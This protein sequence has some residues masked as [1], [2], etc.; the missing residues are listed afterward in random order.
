MPSIGW[1]A[2]EGILALGLLVGVTACGGGGGS[3]TGDAGA[4]GGP[5]KVLSI[6]VGD[7]EV[8]EINRA[9]EI[10]FNKAVDFDTVNLNTIAIDAMGLQ[11]QAI[12]PASGEFFMKT[13]KVVVFQPTCPLAPDYSDAGLQPGGVMYALTVRGGK[14]GGPKLR[15]KSGQKLDKS[16]SVSF[17]T[18]ASLDPS[19][20]FADP[21]DGPPAPVV[22]LVGS[23][24]LNATYLSIGADDDERVYFEF[25]P[26]SF[27]YSEPQDVPLNFMS[28]VTTAVAVILEL[29][30]PI[31][32]AATN[33]NPSRLRLECDGGVGAWAP[34]PTKLE[35]LQNC[36]STGARIRLVP[37][38]A[39]PQ[40]SNIRVVVDAGFEDLVGQTN[41]LPLNDFAVFSTRVLNDPGFDP[42]GVIADEFRDDF[43]FGGALSFEDEA[44]VF[45]EPSA[46]WGDGRLK[47]V[48][49]F[50][51]TGGPGGEF[52]WRIPAGTSLVLDATSGTIV[53][54]P[55]FD[56][57]LQQAVVDG[58]V[59]VRDF[60]VESGASLRIE[61]AMGLHLRASG[62]VRIEGRIDV[63]GFDASQPPSLDPGSH[64]SMGAPGAG[65]GGRGGLASPEPA[66]SS[67]AGGHG[68]GSFGV[69]MMGGCGGESGY[70]SGGFDKT[71]AGGGGGGVFSPKQSGLN[72][73]LEALPGEKGSSLAKGAQ[74]GQ[75]QPKGGVVG[76]SPFQ[77]GDPSNDFF[78]ARID[79][80]TGEL[81]QGELS[82]PMAGSGGGAGGDSVLSGTFPNPSFPN[83]DRKGASGGGGAGFLYMQAQG[84]IVIGPSGRIIADGGRGAS[85]QSLSGGSPLG[86]GSG[87]GSGGHIVMEAGGKLDF[88]LLGVGA[89]TALGGKGGKGNTAYG[90]FGSGGSGGPGLIQ[91]HAAGVAEGGLLLPP[92]VS[93]ATRFSPAPKVL[94]PTFGRRS[95]ARSKWIPLGAA[96]CDP[97]G[98]AVTTFFFGGIDPATGKVLD[99]NKDG[100]VDDVPALLGPETLNVG[101]DVPYVALDG[102]TLL[103]DA[104]TLLGKPQ[105]LYLRNTALLRSFAIVLE[106]VS[107]PASSA[108]FDVAAATYNSVTA[109]LALTVAS[110][111]PTLTS[112][113]PGSAVRYRLIPRF[114][115]VF[116]GAE[117]DTLDP[118]SSITVRFQGTGASAAGLPSDSP[119]TGWTSNIADLTAKPVAFLRFEVLFDLGDAVTG[120]EPGDDLPSLDFLRV[121][122]RR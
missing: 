74:T 44:A 105:D 7:G 83:G 82:G 24:D 28:D 71:L 119:V 85:G 120:L 55:N 38:G 78:G 106:Q 91:I 9:I 107:N 117:A 23:Q 43:D 63:C 51:G 116:T 101:P 25:D 33:L 52:D 100:E 65:G 18:P 57:S 36:S 81:V 95:R 72:P 70:G 8:F 13:P 50:A 48:N 97:G 86:G 114:F 31:D 58:L 108:R 26:A 40:A 54:G 76:S 4:G 80:I 118:L 94:V 112:F 30:Q 110:N 92:G 66:Q 11:A 53:G 45:E 67:A 98:P 1:K 29:D 121:P 21:V 64:P 102:R 15:A 62:D 3:A 84:D 46:Q 104:H 68:E 75:M 122:F 14:A 115:Q 2:K 73:G 5:F 49:G 34:V 12:A 109:E 19:V 42:P 103:V 56:G 39:L 88:R 77:D 16:S 113:A 79:P 20:V 37:L 47:A 22:R 10:A 27:T 61:G 87:G 90:H 41:M 35:L 60:V 6:S 99:A 89:I 69:P 96:A 59:D 111:G 17:L 93:L 32:G